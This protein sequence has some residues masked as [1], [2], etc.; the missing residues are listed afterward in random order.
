[1]R[2]KLMRANSMKHAALGVVSALVCAATA[3]AQSI[4]DANVADGNA[5][6]GEVLAQRSVEQRI[7]AGDEVLNHLGGNHEDRF[8]RAP[9]YGRMGVKVAFDAQRSDEALR[10]GAFREASE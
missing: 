1:M 8:T 5:A 4:A 9:V 7:P 2:A 10:N 6:R 3:G